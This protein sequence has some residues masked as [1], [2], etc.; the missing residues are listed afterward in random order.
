[1]KVCETVP[2]GDDQYD[3]AINSSM[4]PETSEKS[5]ETIFPALLANDDLINDVRESCISGQFEYFQHE[6][7]CSLFYHCHHGTPVVKSC[8]SPTL[9]NPEQLNCDWAENVW[10]VR[11][12]CQLDVTATP[13]SV[14][15]EGGQPST[16]VI[17]QSSRTPPG[18]CDTDKYGGQDLIY[19]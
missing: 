10:R 8:V 7:N 13:A 2:C 12:G 14:E 5:E 3:E 9:F 6:T 4:L 19:H 16:I 15:E 18:H 1:M 17:V 11:P